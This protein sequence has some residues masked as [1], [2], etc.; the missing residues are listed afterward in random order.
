[1]LASLS[2]IYS[3]GLPDTYRAPM[4]NTIAACVGSKD[5][6]SQVACPCTVGRPVTESFVKFNRRQIQEALR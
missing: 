6:Q 4:A 5:I 1:M 2:K 3:A